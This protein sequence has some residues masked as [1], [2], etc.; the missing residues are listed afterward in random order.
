MNQHQK[1]IHCGAPSVVLL[2]ETCAAKSNA[3]REARAA[4][5]KENGRL[6]TEQY[7]ELCE[8]CTRSK[9]VNTLGIPVCDCL[10]IQPYAMSSYPGEHK[11]VPIHPNNG[12]E[13]A[14]YRREDVEA[15]LERVRK[16]ENGECPKCGGSRIVPLPRHADA[17]ACLGPLGGGGRGVSLT[18]R[19]E[20]KA[21][22][23]PSSPTREVTP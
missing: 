21:Q 8:V 12:D 17:C 18:V 3:E 22:N 11:L 6:R 19:K 4:A 16:L 5:L 10:G 20:P 1:C 23:D 15:L 14:W 2:C 13:Q 9:T 7:P